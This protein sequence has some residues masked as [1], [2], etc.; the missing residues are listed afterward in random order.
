MVNLKPYLKIVKNS[1]VLAITMLLLLGVIIPSVTALISEHIDPS[2][3]NGSPIE[4]NGKIYGSYLLAQAFN[5]SSL[6]FQAR[7]STIGYNQ[8][9]SG[10]CT[11]T[12]DSQQ[13]L[14]FTLNALREFESKNPGINLSSVPFEMVAY[15][16]SGLDPNIPI[17]GA[18]IQIPRIASNLS[19]LF[20]KS[21]SV[22]TLEK[23]LLNF[24]NSSEQQNFPIFGTYYAN[25]MELNVDIINLMIKNGVVPKSLLD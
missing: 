1:S 13:A 22:I 21:V 5:N 7:P 3:S 18:Y 20:N 14:N 6:F 9:E 11:G 2:S 10:S 23:E 24:V 17:Q 8:T 15:S 16:A 12:A 19:L 25:T 4:I